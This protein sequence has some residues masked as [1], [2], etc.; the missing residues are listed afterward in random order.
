MVTAT[1]CKTVSHGFESRRHLQNPHANSVEVFVASLQGYRIVVTAGG[2]RE[3]IDPVRFV[4]N[5]SS[6]KMGYA[7]AAEAR[8]RGARVTLITTA[9]L[10]PPRGVAIRTVDTAESMLKAVLEESAHADALVMAAA[11]ADY[12]P[13]ISS[14]KKLKAEARPRL[15]VRLK[16]TADI[17][18]AVRRIVPANFVR[19]GFAAETEALLRNGLGKLVRKDLDMIVVNQVPE[20]FGADKARAIF[21][22]RKGGVEKLPLLSKTRL[23]CRILGRLGD[24]LRAKDG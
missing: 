13:I 19:I 4:G 11:V 23:A 5:R 18:Q 9:S 6:G 20:T 2:T 10:R 7:L 22:D 3:P 12:T 14:P 24:L 15:V 16:R 8:R 21:L 17:L 1:V